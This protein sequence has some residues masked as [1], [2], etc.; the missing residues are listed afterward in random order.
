MATIGAVVI[1]GL[2][3]SNGA[4]GSWQC[5]MARSVVEPLQADQRS[6]I[7]ETMVTTSSPRPDRRQSRRSGLP[8]SGGRAPEGRVA[9]REGPAVGGDHPIAEAV[10]GRR[11]PGHRGVQRDAPQ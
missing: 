9:E 8:G 1:P 11:H 2:L 4:S 6:S 7:L 3:P 10:V 5:R